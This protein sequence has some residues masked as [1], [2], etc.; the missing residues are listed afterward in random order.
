MGSPRY[1]VL[2][3]VT[4]PGAVA[5]ISANGHAESPPAKR[6]YLPRPR[7][8]S[9]VIMGAS[10]SGKSSLWAALTGRDDPRSMSRST[11]DGYFVLPD[12]RS[13]AIFT[14]PGQDSSNR[15]SALD[16]VFG[17]NTDVAGIVFLVSYGFDH[18]WPAY[19][20]TVASSLDPFALGELRQRNLREE[21]DDLQE[22]VESIA[23]K[24]HKAPRSFMPDWIVYVM[25]K[26]DLYWNEIE[27]AG[28]YYFRDS[29]SDFVQV[30][31]SLFE[32]VGNQLL[33]SHDLPLMTQVADY[34]FAS[35]RGSLHRPTQLTKNHRDAAMLCLLEKLEELI[36]E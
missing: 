13:P 24:L 12:R 14:I 34:V 6:L 11:D 23:R 31:R 1:T 29:D 36:H 28:D 20:N 27:A 35:D 25:S 19:A 22:L 7:A 10:G 4:W 15:D 3:M 18:I 2:R 26:A 17:S 30:R 21:L 33:T 32:R 8:R 5:R 16:T 9:V